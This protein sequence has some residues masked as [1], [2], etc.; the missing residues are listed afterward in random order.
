MREGQPVST[1]GQERVLRG[2]HQHRIAN[3]EKPSEEPGVVR[4]PSLW[5]RAEN[6]R[7]PLQ[8]G[9]YRE[10]SEPAQDETC[11]KNHK[12]DPNS[13][14]EGVGLGTGHMACLTHASAAAGQRRRG[15]Y[16]GQ[17]ARRP[18]NAVVGW[19][20]TTP[21]AHGRAKSECRTIARCES[22]MGSRNCVECRPPVATSCVP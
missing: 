3:G 16:L 1:V 8:L 5:A 11:H 9:Y 17:P 7:E 14:L 10:S 20:L 18:L 21:T 6:A 15:S 4:R 22:P 12:E 2:G 19:H 13:S